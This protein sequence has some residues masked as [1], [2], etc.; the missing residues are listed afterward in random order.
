M[1]PDGGSGGRAGRLH[2]GALDEPFEPRR[3]PGPGVAPSVVEGAEIQVVEGAGRRDRTDV[4]RLAEALRL[5]FESVDRPPELAPLAV[6]PIRPPVLRRTEDLL[7]AAKDRRVEESVRERLAAK[8]GPPIRPGRGEQP[9]A[10]VQRVEILADD[11][12]IEERGAV[13]ED[14]GGD[15]AERILPVEIGVGRDRG[16]RDGGD[17]DPVRES[18]SWATA[19]VLRT[20]GEAGLWK[21]FMGGILLSRAKESVRGSEPRTRRSRLRAAG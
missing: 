9:G 3:E 17:L 2:R 10:V 8:R 13:V 18:A 19:S 1:R 5:V 16:E 11:P 14:E 6:H 21:S 7:V 20:N 12:G 15:L 4:H